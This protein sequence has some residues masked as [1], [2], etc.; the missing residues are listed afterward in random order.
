MNTMKNGFKK[1][2]FLG[3]AMLLL[4]GSCEKNDISINNEKTIIEPLQPKSLIGNSDYDKSWRIVDSL[5]RK[6]LQ[7]SALEVVTVIMEK[8][9]KELNQPQQIKALFYQLKYQQNLEEDAF[10]KALQQID[11]LRKTN[12]I[13]LKQLLSSVKAELLWGY[14]QNNRYRFYNRSTTSS[15]DLSDVTTWDLKTLLSESEKLHMASLEDREKSQQINLNDYEYILE[16]ATV[17]GYETTPTVFDF[18]A[19]RALV[20]FENDETSITRPAD[21]FTVNDERYFGTDNEFLAI[22]TDSEDTLSNMLYYVKT[23]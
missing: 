13:P 3:I 14:F 18:L 22:S 1:I 7:K 8:A 2:A 20:F 15:F 17:E 21:K 9:V 5:D 10:V 16:G 12:Q 19:Y 4:S 23:M 11:D 6:G